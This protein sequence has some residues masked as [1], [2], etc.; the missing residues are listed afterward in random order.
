MTKILQLKTSLFADHGVSSQL[1]KDFIDQF[2]TANPD[3]SLKVRNFAEEAIPHLDAGYLQALSTEAAER[4]AEQQQLVDFSDSLINELMD[5]DVLVLGLPMY[6]FGV[7]SMLKAWIDHV[8]RAQVT[9]RYTENGPEGLLKGKKAYVLAS[10]GGLY[11]GTP[12]DSQTPFI[13][14]FLAFIGITDVNFVYAEGLNMG[15]E[16]R[17]AAMDKAGAEIQALANA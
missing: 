9:F 16:P 5:A 2:M 12:A 7:P 11:A 4:S 3:S 8:A 1:S 13:T 15:D 14:N 6:N 10:R 17:A